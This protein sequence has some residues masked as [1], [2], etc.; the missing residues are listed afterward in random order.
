MVFAI[1][2]ALI[3]NLVVWNQ[4]NAPG[5][6]AFCGLMTAVIIWAIASVGEFTAVS[7]SS[8]VL[9]SKISYIGIV[10]TPPAWLLFAANYSHRKGWQS[11]KQYLWLWIIPSVILLLVMTNEWHGL[12]WSSIIPISKEVGAWLIY[13][14][15]IAFYINTVYAY[16]LLLIGSF[17]LLAFAIRYQSLYR[18]QVGTLIIGVLIPFSGNLLYI[19]RLN[20]WPGLDITP[21][22]FAFSGLLF[23][24]S[25]FSHKLF[26]ITPI[27][28]EKLFES[29]KEGIIVLDLENKILDI[30]PSACRLFNRD[31]AQVIG[32]EIGL[33][34]SNQQELVEKY[35]TAREAHAIIEISQSQVIELNITPIYNHRNQYSGRLIVLR[36]ITEQRYFEK[37][38]AEQ[39][40]FLTQVMDAIPIG[41]TVTDQQGKFDYVNP[42]YANI[43]ELTPGDLIGQSPYDYTLPEFHPTLKNEMEN[44]SK[45]VTSVY[46]TNLKK[47]GG[48]IVPVLINAAPRKVEDQIFGT[49]AAVSDLSEQKQIEASLAYR[50]AFE[51]EL[52]YLSA[53]FVN[54]SV[55]EIDGLF[56]RSLKRIG[57]FCFVDRAYIFNVDSLAITMSNTHEWCAEGISPQ[58]E[59]LQNIAC[60]VFPMWMQT[61]QN[62]EHIY[63]ASV[64]DLPDSW[65]AE[66]EI[67]ESQAIKSLLVIPIVYSNTLLGFA[68]FDSV[69][70]Y[71]VWKDEEIQLLHLLGNIIASA[72]K[73]KEANLE[74]LITN[75]HLAESTLRANEMAIQAEA[76]NLAKS[77]FVANM[78]HEVRTPMNGVL[79]M[80]GLLLNT[81]L[82]KEQRHYAEVIHKSAESLLV[83]IND[84]LDFSKIEAGKMGLEKIE[85]HFSTMIN[86][87]YSTF[88]YRAQE[89][90]IAFRYDVSPDIPA[91][92][93]GDPERLRQVINNL[94]SNAIK[95]TES[96]EVC[97]TAGLEQLSTTIA[98]VRIQIQDTGIGIP[99]EKVDQ[100]FQ[101]FTQLD[102]SISRSFGG[103][104]LGLSIT[105]ELVEMMLGNIGVESNLGIGSKF[106]VVLPLE[107]SKNQNIET[108]YN[109]NKSASP[110]KNILKG[111]H[112]LL[113][114][115]N[116]I[117]QEIVNAIFNHWDVQVTSVNNGAEALEELQNK[118]YDLVLMDVNM[119][120]MDGLSATQ[121]IREPSSP[122]LNHEI[123]IIAMTASAMRGD[124]EQCLQV[125][126][127]DYISKP[128][129]TEE[130]TAKIVYWIQHI[131]H[132]SQTSST[133]GLTQTNVD[134]NR[135]LPDR[136]DKLVPVI[137]FD[138][139]C[140]R[141]LNDEELAYN[142]IHKA[143]ARLDGTINSIEQAIINK[144]A[145]EIK[146]LAHKL[147]GSAGNLSAEPLRQACEDLENASLTLNWEEIDLHWQN[148]SQQAQRFKLAAENLLAVKTV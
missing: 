33:V 142:L 118:P 21:L 79:G 50:E 53:D 103:T 135:S 87:V 9:W 2:L 132:N 115:D 40:D 96:G 41:V 37:A 66:R 75:Q 38:L 17:W 44:R 121:R 116:E 133:H 59:N 68:G 86:D 106:W 52:I 73:R 28:R 126:M 141:V 1:I 90:G 97:F 39:R 91:V 80:T 139:L 81:R 134:Y 24:W 7:Y 92:L 56:Y 35:Q 124:R 47:P 83:V 95:F 123:P 129:N 8:K 110:D 127:N 119:P 19:L 45:G 49:I 102:N 27:A 5:R 65:H 18:R 99:P 98:E 60:D 12:I 64:K 125:G 128:F 67:L 88:S 148:F 104:G 29:M 77:Q 145:D 93:I 112:I 100:L 32:K 58:I 13:H 25:L 20:P 61:L 36:E 15:G 143:L 6:L 70:N 107:I 144:N 140:H 34:I 130:L 3:V 16:L 46:E 137:E 31:A 14:H 11:G 48:E 85:F 30:N 89:K 57:E 131:Q 94:I 10:N 82:E 51:K 147:K 105:K 108:L 138:Q 4:R 111:A 22:S 42:A 84:I 55:D 120:E 101:P 136:D 71:R 43:L 26:S 76:A 114:E 69:N 113:A 23:A 122:V 78:S 54:V 74:I 62:F 146:T 109:K 117:N 63:I 72:I